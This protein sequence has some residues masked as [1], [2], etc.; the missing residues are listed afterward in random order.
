MKK[1]LVD[2]IRLVQPMLTTLITSS[3]N[4]RNAVMAAAWVTPV[5]YV[6]PRVGVAISPERYT[7]DIV[8]SSGYFAI[9]IMD[10]KYTYNI[11]LAGTLS[12]KNYE[13]KFKAIGLTPIKAKKLNIVVVKEA[14]GILEC[15]VIKIIETGDHHLFIADIIEAY[16]NNDKAYNTHWVI[17]HYKPVLYISEGHFLTIDRNSL[18]K[19]GVR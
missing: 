1:I 14:I 19:Y 11:Y 9:N 10:F 3:Y 13:D 2:Q 18:V 4:G 12:G 8:K 17:S 6:P 15:K 7:Y 5:S 16:V